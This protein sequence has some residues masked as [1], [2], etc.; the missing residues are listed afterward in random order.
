MKLFIDLQGTQTP[1]SRKRGIGRYSRDLSAALIREAP[2][3]SSIALGW[4]KAFETPL[5]EMD[6]G[7][8]ARSDLDLISYPYGILKRPKYQFRRHDIYQEVN[9]RLFR[10][11]VAR[12]GCE[13][14]IFTS[15]IENAE[16][17]FAQPLNLNFAAR[18]SSYS[19]IYDIIP[20]IFKEKYLSTEALFSNYMSQISVALSATTIFTISEQTKKDLLEHFDIEEARVVNIGTGI[21]C[22]QF[23]MTRAKLVEPL[24]V[25]RPYLLFLGGDEFRKNLT[26]FVQAYCRLPD[27][28]KT[29]LQAVVVGKV[30]EATKQSICELAQQE[31]LPADTIQFT[32][33][34]CQAGLIQAYHEC[35]LVVIPSLYEGF[36]LPALEAMACGAPV[37]ASKNT[38]LADLIPDDAFLFDPAAPQDIANTIEFALTHHERV[39][40]LKAEYPRVLA[41]HTWSAVA[42]RV[43]AEL[44]ASQARQEKAFWAS[45]TTQPPMDLAIVL[46]SPPSQDLRHRINLLARY[47]TIKV[48]FKD[49]CSEIDSLPV[50]VEHISRLWTRAYGDTPVFHLADDHAEFEWMSK[51]YPVFNMIAVLSK[52]RAAPLNDQPSHGY[53]ATWFDYPN[54]LLLAVQKACETYRVGSPLKLATDLKATMNKAGA[55]RR[56]IK[57]LSKSAGIVFLESKK[58]TGDCPSSF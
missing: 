45:V 55:S 25:T 32:E 52:K 39:Q 33:Y 27:V 19:I 44:K 3:S 28:L 21:D 14:I 51:H 37:I 30:A 10:Y 43:F 6:T 2:P 42:K 23:Q 36:G 9:D 26:G 11:A 58:L 5:D 49:L 46:T 18:S 17:N 8:G 16:E 35:A 24:P 48:Y 38:S 57:D 4:N 56:Y 20:L 34:L 54:D 22:E 13:H 53:Y 41:Q 40:Q 7:N 29:G 12:S 15:L 50:P 1:G 31:G 47:H